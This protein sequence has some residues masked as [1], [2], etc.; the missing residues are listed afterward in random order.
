MA[1]V[2]VGDYPQFGDSLEP[3][4]IQQREQQST[5][6]G[7]RKG[8]QKYPGEHQSG[9]FAYQHPNAN[10]KIRFSHYAASLLSLAFVRS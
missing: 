6:P 8:G 9:W 10:K 1:K 2:T 4:S 7:R 3:K 5:Q